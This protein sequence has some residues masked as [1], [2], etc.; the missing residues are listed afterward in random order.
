MTKLQFEQLQGIQRRDDILRY[1]LSFTPDHWP[2]SIREIG[3]AV[4]LRSPSTTLHHLRVL[5]EQG[6]IVRGAGDRQIR[7]TLK[8][9]A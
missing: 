5:E 9:T 8:A 2:P 3:E 7:V 4:G 6:W 1:L